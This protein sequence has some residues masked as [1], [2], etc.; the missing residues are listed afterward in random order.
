MYVNCHVQHQL[1]GISEQSA[2]GIQVVTRHVYP[3]LL[4]EDIVQIR[5]IVLPGMETC[6]MHT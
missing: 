4:E 5:V 6:T 1:N 2:F 3:Q